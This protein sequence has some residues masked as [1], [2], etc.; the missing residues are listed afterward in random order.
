[1]RWFYF[2]YSIKEKEFNF[3]FDNKPKK[4]IDVETGATIN[5]FADTIKDS[6]GE[7]VSSYFNALRLKCAQYKIKYV[8]ADIN[9]PLSN[10]LTTY[11]LE[12]QKFL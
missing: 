12:R 8:E 1:M 9:K 11:M 5:L 6:Y 10:V 2:M 3:N 7:A 4:F